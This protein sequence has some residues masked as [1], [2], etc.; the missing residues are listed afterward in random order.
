MKSGNGKKNDKARSE[1]KKLL[2]IKKAHP[3]KEQGFTLIEALVGIFLMGVVL[4]GLAQLFVLGV[5]NNIS[6]E[7]ISNALFLS[8]EQIDSLRNFTS[9]ELDALSS[10]IDEQMD[11]NSDGTVDY[12]RLTIISPSGFQYNIRVLVFAAEQIGVEVDSL[13]A[14]PRT[15][16]VK[17]QMDTIISR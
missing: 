17:S 14:S 13:L 2:M 11:V 1:M 10:P 4:L 7:Q 16:G 6:S 8:Q 15:Y 9:A 5:L 12:R 3:S